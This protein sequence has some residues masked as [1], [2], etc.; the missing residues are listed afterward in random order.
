M[1]NQAKGADDKVTKF[2]QELRNAPS[3]ETAL[4][5]M[6]KAED[7]TGI[8]FAPPGDCEHWAFIPKGA[9]KDINSVGRLPCGGHFHTLAEIQLQTPGSDV[10]KAFASVATLHRIKLAN[11]TTRAANDGPPKDF[12]CTNWKWDLNSGGWVCQD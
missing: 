11:V 1:A 2:I 10:E 4:Y 12:P 6:V 8:L 7:D 5:G 3:K 9:I